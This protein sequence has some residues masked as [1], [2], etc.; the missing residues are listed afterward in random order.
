[1]FIATQNT[2]VSGL[3]PPLQYAVPHSEAGTVSVPA[4]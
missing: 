4:M 2:W 3:C 1:M